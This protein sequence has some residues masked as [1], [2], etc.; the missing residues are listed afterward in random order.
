MMTR[1]YI[2]QTAGSMKTMSKYGKTLSRNICSNLTLYVFFRKAKQH[3]VC[4][5]VI[6][7]HPEY[8]KVTQHCVGCFIIAQCADNMLQLFLKQIYD[9][10]NL[11]SHALNDALF[12]SAE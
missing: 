2:S 6:T 9:V 8:D 4:A 5:C 12:N 7:K 10:K 11:E 1:G 3:D